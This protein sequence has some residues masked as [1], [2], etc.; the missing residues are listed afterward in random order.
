MPG[1]PSSAVGMQKFNNLLVVVDTL[2]KQVHLVPT[3]KDVTAE[4][5][6]QLYFDNI[7]KLHGLPKA[8]ISDR[9]T[10]FTGAFWRTLQKMVGTDLMMSTSDHPQTDG[11]TERMNRTILQILRQFV[12]TNRSDWAQHIATVEFAINSSINQSTG[13]A[14]F[15]LL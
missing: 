13:K 14:P 5:V 4:G 6:A 2:T 11:Q 15:E 1:L 10:K 3:T 8:I 12:N 9:D 7:Y